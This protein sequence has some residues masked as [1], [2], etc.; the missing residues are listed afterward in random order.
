M[1][2]RATTKVGQLVRIRLVRKFMRRARTNRR[3]PVVPVVLSFGALCFI[4]AAGLMYFE[5]QVG[6]D[7]SWSDS[8]WWAIVTMTTVGYG[9]IVPDTAAAR[10][11]V[12]V[13]IMIFGIGVLGYLFSVVASGFVDARNRRLKG[14]GKMECKG[15][16]VLVHTQSIG[17]IVDVVK[18]LQSLPKT[19]KA[20]IV[21]L[22]N[23][24]ESLPPE[25]SDLGVDFVHGSPVA[26][27]SFVRAGIS[28]A[29]AAIVLALMPGKPESDI[30]SVAAVVALKAARRDLYVVAECIDPANVGLLEKS[31]ADATV[32]TAALTSALLTQE[33]SDA[34][35]QGIMQSLVTAKTGQH[36][37]V[38]AI[39]GDGERMFSDVRDRLRDAGSLT[40]GI[41]RDGAPVFNPGDGYALKVGDRA[42][43]IAA[44]R[45]ANVMG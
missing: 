30:R 42:I 16:I 6:R 38:V 7:L 34:G 10:F 19:A 22:G 14:L 37:F 43:C 31:G 21:V 11:L 29:R 41:E 15:H 3:H 33:V 1:K 45:P 39:E 44:E 13:P 20:P 27:D 36:M 2:S 28:E 4:G 25:L 40:L 23:R 32:C 26:E 18:Q 24:I 5:G 12:G 9:E 8:L 35:V 17:R